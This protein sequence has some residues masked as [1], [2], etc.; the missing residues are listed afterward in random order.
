VGCTAIT[1]D[2]SDVVAV[3]YTGPA[4]PSVFE[5]DTV[6]LTAVALDRNGNLLPDVTVLWRILEPDTV[7]VGI[8]L[9]S[10]TGLVTGLFAGAW[11]VQ[12][13]ADGLRTATLTVTVRGVADSIAAVL[14]ELTFPAADTESPSLGA[15]VYDVSPT[16]VATPLAAAPVRFT[17]VSPVPGTAEAATLALAAAGQAPGEDPHT[18]AFSTVANG[19]AFATLRRVGLGQPDTAIVEAVALAPGGGIIPGAPARFTVLIVNN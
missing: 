1:G 15:A 6:R 12:G 3:V 18:A 5:D 10:L 8:A 9:D 14:D 17:L 11:R 16:G 2:F 13:D 7:Q 4:T 19:I